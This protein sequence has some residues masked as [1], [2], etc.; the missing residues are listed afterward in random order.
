[1]ESHL[2][3][4]IDFLTTH[5]TLA[6]V[7]IFGAS[8]LEA[9]AVIGTIIPGSSVVFAGGVLIGL[10]VLAPLPVTLLAV[11]G[12]I[13]GDGIS[14]WLG[15]RFQATIPTLWPLK[16]Y[17]AL[18]E[19]GQAYFT[20]YGGKSVFLARFIGPLRAIVPVVAGMSGMPA[21]LFYS[22]NI[23]S[24]LIWAALHIVPGVLFGASLQLAAAVSARLVILLIL[25]TAIFWI[26]FKCARLAHRQAWPR[27]GL[28]RDRVVAWARADARMPA[29]IVLS[30]LDPAKPASQGL[31]GAA[32]LLIGSSMLFFGILQDI[33]AGDPLVQ[34]D[35]TVYVTLQSLRTGWGDDLMVAASE[36]G[37]A[38]VTMPV[39]VAVA[40]LFAL[41]RHW[42]TLGYW[43]GSAA[44]AEILVR[45]LK[46]T[47]GRARPND[48][49]S[50]VE[51]FSFPS[52]HAALSMV[53]YGFLAFLLAR[54]KPAWAKIAITLLCASAILMIAFSRLYLGAHWFSDVAGSFSLGLAW[55]ALLCIAYTHHAARQPMQRTSA[56][57]SAWPLPLV[58]LI[59]I[60]L[61]GG[62]V[63]RDQHAADLA[64]YTYQPRLD[65]MPL[66]TW[67]A[68]GWR[69]LP[70]A[71]SELGGEFE[72]PFSVQWAASAAQISA[73]LRAGGWQQPPAWRGTTFLLWLISGT[74]LQ[75]LPVLAKFD[76]GAAQQTT[77]IKAVDARQ[78]MVI[79]FWPQRY[80]VDASAGTPAR[81]LW[82][83]MVTTERLRQAIGLITLAQTAADFATPL[84][85]L[86]ADLRKSPWSITTMH[87]YQGD[88][89]LIW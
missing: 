67:Q 82:L 32:V 26:L 12:A 58:V 35:Q 65:S 71:R 61:A 18:F 23:L 62:M 68:D 10:K 15:H 75:Q 63:V 66:P 20:K 56:S 42:V 6:Q 28:W 8:L 77:F 59:T 79:R 52:G 43:L 53:V 16:R 73:S 7:L 30:L 64:R 33:L 4:L 54:G 80:A 47:L 9:L 88:V 19:R 1:M 36:L 17:P 45:V 29:R 22:M 57:L 38:N 85:T 27:I 39:I 11:T 74:P 78:R 83:A 48:I 44:V 40:L 60:V 70:V 37:S 86:A 21:R 69:T 5:P 51:R 50:G 84:R 46:F 13:L 24:A 25:F 34:F 31:L 41:Q 3:A 72:E 89:L 55:V 14:Y 81:P 2:Q 87:R 49:Y 76:H